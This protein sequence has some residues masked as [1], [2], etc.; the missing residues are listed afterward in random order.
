MF[1]QATLTSGPAGKRV[2][3]T[4]LGFTSQ[5]VL[6]TFAVMAP[7]MWPQML[8]PTHI[9][10]TLVPPAPPAPPHLGT[11]KHDP[12]SARPLQ[13]VPWSLIKYQPTSVPTSIPAIVEEPAGIGVAGMPQGFSN[14]NENGVMGSFMTD[15]AAHISPVAPPRVVASPAKPPEAPVVIQRFKAGGNVHLGA[16]LHKVEPAYPAIAKSAHVSGD[17]ELECVVGVDGHIHEVK[18]TGGNP[19][20]V[21]AAVDAAWQWVYTPSRLNDVPIEIIT[22]LK[23]SF[24]LN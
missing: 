24:K 1:E 12:A 7:M 8:P 17:V 5:A 15:L 20:L 23:F 3:A 16:V 10:D 21:R 4:F 11:V 14:G 9:W 6:L 22:I 2:W 13:H 19:L 18:V